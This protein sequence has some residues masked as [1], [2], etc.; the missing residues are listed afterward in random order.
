[1]GRFLKQLL[2]L[3]PFG[4]FIAC[5]CMIRM[6]PGFSF[7]SWLLWGCAG[8][9]LVYRLLTWM[10]KKK[11][12]LSKWLLWILTVGL[13]LVL[14]AGTVTG[15]IIGTAGHGDADTSCDYVIVLGAGVNGTRPSLILSERIERAYTYLRDNPDTVAI[16]SGGQGPGENISE[17]QCMFNSLTEKGIAAERLWLEDKSTSTRENL[18]FSL[19]LI[20]G[21]TG[22]R[23]AQAAI[24]SNEFHLYRA[25][26][27][28]AEQELQMIGVPAR[29]T[30]FSLR[31]NYFLREIVAVW[32]YT[33]LGG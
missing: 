30:W 13:C 1:M 26:L 27:F 20:E 19:E 18:R 3:I 2:W 31:A 22:S 16:L 9:V 24:V 25:G 7:S 14:V 8:I 28:A 6:I 12:K 17:A 5:G 4:F 32:Y 10:K 21:K 29:T 33:I 15:I 11:P 23:P